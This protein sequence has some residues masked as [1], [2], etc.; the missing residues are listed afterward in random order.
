[1]HRHSAKFNEKFTVEVQNCGD[2][3]YQQKN[4]ADD[5]LFMEVAG[6]IS[7][8]RSKTEGVR[9]LGEIDKIYLENTNL[10]QQ[11]G[12]D[13]QNAGNVQAKKKIN[14]TIVGNEVSTSSMAD[15]KNNDIDFEI[16][17]KTIGR[18]QYNPHREVLWSRTKLN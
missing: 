6:I 12:N 10:V 11:L 1:M 4:I 17:G 16:A 15:F 13:N 18:K 5:P 3:Q 2:A 14:Q 8:I 7:Q 9:A